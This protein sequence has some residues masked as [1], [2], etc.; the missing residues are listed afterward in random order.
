MHNGMRHNWCLRLIFTAW[1]KQEWW[2]WGF[3]LACLQR[4]RCRANRTVKVWTVYLWF[5]SGK[6]KTSGGKQ[7]I[8]RTEVCMKEVGQRTKLRLVIRKLN[9]VRSRAERGICPRCRV[10]RTD[11]HILL[12]RKE[13]QRRGQKHL[14]CKSLIIHEATA[15]RH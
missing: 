9:W 5:L 10:G 15:V 7:N 4:V 14:N 11:M 2:E 8:Y 12:K 13:R 3:M 6:W 1:L